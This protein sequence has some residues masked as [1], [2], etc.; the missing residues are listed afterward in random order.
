MISSSA[1][2]SDMTGMR[3]IVA[4]SSLDAASSPAEAASVLTDAS[5]VMLCISAFKV[6]CKALSSDVTWACSSRPTR[7]VMVKQARVHLQF[8]TI[9][10]CFFVCTRMCT[11]TQMNGIHASTYPAMQCTLESQASKVQIC[12]IG[13]TMFTVGPK[14]I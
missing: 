13:V 8:V 10:L 11:R 1:F 12:A 4:D 14:A 7:R 5:G 6:S 3:I 9:C 2:L